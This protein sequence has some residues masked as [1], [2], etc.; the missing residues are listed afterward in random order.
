MRLSETPSQ[1]S[2][3]P[4]SSKWFTSRESSWAAGRRR[5]GGID[6]LAGDGRLRRR[7][8]RGVGLDRRILRLS[9]RVGLG[10]V[11]N[12]GRLG[13]LLGGVFGPGLRSRPRAIEVGLLA[14]RRDGGD[15]GQ[16]R[17]GDDKGA[18]HLRISFQRSIS[19]R[20]RSGAVPPKLVRLFAEAAGVSTS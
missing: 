14:A 15:E 16:A 18:L 11:V 4:E 1:A 13:A 19:A 7:R 12:L 17:E 5:P 9:D 20:T 8:R 10:L 6:P 2:S 3:P